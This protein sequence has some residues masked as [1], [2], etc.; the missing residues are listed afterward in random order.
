M[1]FDSLSDTNELL[2]FITVR[3]YFVSFWNWNFEVLFY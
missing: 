2:N 1:Y 3:C